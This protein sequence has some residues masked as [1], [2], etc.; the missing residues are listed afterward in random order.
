MKRLEEVMK[1][2][3]NWLLKLANRPIKYKKNHKFLNYLLQNFFSE[4]CRISGECRWF[5]NSSFQ[6]RRNVRPSRRLPRQ[7]RIYSSSTSWC[8]DDLTHRTTV[9]DR[10]IPYHP[11]SGTVLHSFAV[12]I[13]IDQWSHAN[14]YSNNPVCSRI[15]FFLFFVNKLIQCGQAS[16]H[17]LI[18][19]LP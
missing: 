13:T 11:P 14:Y 4:S 18:P 15:L 6:R 2:T 1:H 17:R 7:T 12:L 19:T 3:W 9:F 16:R 10:S 8:S 5:A